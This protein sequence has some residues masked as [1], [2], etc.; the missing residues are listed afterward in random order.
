[1]GVPEEEL[2]YLEEN[3]S[4]SIFDQCAPA[5]VPEV[6]IQAAAEK[7]LLVIE[8]FP[9]RINRITLRNKANIRDLYPRRFNQPR[10][11]RRN[12]RSSGAT[13]SQGLFR[14][15]ACP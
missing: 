4:T 2:F 7:T 15:I 1:M 14:F 6:Y 12:H 11:I 8:I 5:I 3:I 13:T 9:A 10:G